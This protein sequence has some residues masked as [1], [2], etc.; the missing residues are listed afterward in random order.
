MTLITSTWGWAI[1]LANGTSYPFSYF[2][3]L[4]GRQYFDTQITIIDCSFPKLSY[5]KTAHDGANDT[6]NMLVLNSY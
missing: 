4:L 1:S 2:S 3:G 6:Y 5:D